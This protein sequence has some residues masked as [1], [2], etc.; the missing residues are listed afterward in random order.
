MNIR[1]EI[2]LPYSSA[3]QNKELMWEYRE[4]KQGCAEDCYR[5]KHSLAKIIVHLRLR[6]GISGE[7]MIIRHFYDCIRYES[8]FGE[9]DFFTDILY[10]MIW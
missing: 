10:L 5:A 2:D 4:N 9:R 8:T 7:A 6:I 3:G 1:I